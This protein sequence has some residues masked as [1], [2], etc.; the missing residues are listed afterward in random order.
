MTVTITNVL[1]QIKQL[2]VAGFW[3][4]FDTDVL[5]DEIKPAVDYRL[6]G[7][8]HFKQIEKLIKNLLLTGKVV[9]IS[10]SIFNPKLDKKRSISKSI[11]DSFGKAF[12]LTG[13]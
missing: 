7:G 1:Q 12:N 10:V 9:G 5:S 13:G 11:S 3:I 2:K 4:H 8:L 6:P